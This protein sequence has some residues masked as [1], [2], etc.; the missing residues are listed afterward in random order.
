MEEV[1]PVEIVL[2]EEIDF[3]DVLEIIEED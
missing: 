3:D 2:P 1:F